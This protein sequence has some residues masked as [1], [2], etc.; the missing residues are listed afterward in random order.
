MGKEV[1]FLCFY[2]KTKNFIRCLKAGKF[3]D[4]NACNFHDFGVQ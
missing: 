2:R 1:Y 4:K 3:Y